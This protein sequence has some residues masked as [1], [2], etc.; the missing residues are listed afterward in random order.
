[1]GATDCKLDMVF[2]NRMS[3]S[4]GTSWESQQGV[5]D[6]MA[7]RAN[8]TCDS[9]TRQ[10]GRC[11]GRFALRSEDSVDSLPIIVIG[12]GL[13]IALALIMGSVDSIARSGAWR[14]IA[15]ARRDLHDE[16]LR[17]LAC[18]TGPRCPDCPL[19]P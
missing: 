13:L 17:L 1:M 3:P 7:S 11:V 19:G 9:H 14:R 4:G 6:R 16:E 12:L 18:R 2:S 5:A 10:P 8:Y 15:D